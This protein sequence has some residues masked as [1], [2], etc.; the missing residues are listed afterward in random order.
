MPHSLQSVRSLQCKVD[1]TFRPKYKSHHK[2]DNKRFQMFLRDY[3]HKWVEK[4]RWKRM[5]SDC[6]ISKFWWKRCHVTSPFSCCKCIKRF[7][8]ERKVIISEPFLSST[9]ILWTHDHLWRPKSFTHTSYAK[10]SL[11]LTS[12]WDIDRLISSS[13]SLNCLSSFVVRAIIDCYMVLEFLMP[14]SYLF[15]RWIQSGIMIV[16]KPF[17]CGWCMVS[18]CY[19]QKFSWRTVAEWV[20]KEASH[21]TISKPSWISFFSAKSKRFYR[22]KRGCCKDI[23]LLLYIWNDKTRVF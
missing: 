21:M 2:C 17:L 1:A 20:W 8:D 15:F 12:F 18:G 9:F 6:D 16:M 14:R 23:S 4:W 22:Y 3:N 10:S 11:R 7:V 19:I 5:W 13:G